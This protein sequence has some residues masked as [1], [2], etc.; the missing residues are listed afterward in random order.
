MACQEI[1]SFFLKRWV[2][3]VPANSILIYCVMEFSRVDI[4]FSLWGKDVSLFEF[5][6][7]LK[8]C[9]EIIVDGIVRTGS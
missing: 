8:R 7:H 2:F 9:C 1:R 5:A 3:R 4:N 6:H